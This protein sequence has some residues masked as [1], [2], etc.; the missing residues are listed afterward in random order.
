[1]RFSLIRKISSIVKIVHV[2][3]G[4]LPDSVGGSEVYCW[5]LCKQLQKQGIQAEVVI[6]GF[7]ENQTTEYY[8]DGIRVTRYA[9]PTVQSRLHI[10][11]LKLPEGLSYFRQYLRE[12]RPDCVHFHGLYPGIGITIQHLAIAKAMKIRV[13]YTMHIPGHICIN[14]TLI[15]NDVEPCDGIIRPLRCAAC[16]L[17]HRGTNKVVSEALAGVSSLLFNEGIDPGLWNN[18]LGT[19]LSAVDRVEDLKIMLAR[20]SILCDR[21]VVLARWFYD[22]M[23]ANHF[24]TEIMEY[25]PPGLTYKNESITNDSS[26]PF[27]RP[28]SIKLIYSGRIDPIKDIQL[29]VQIFNELPENKFELSIYGKPT[30]LSYYAKCRKL[31]ENNPDIHWRGVYS[32]QDLNSIFRQHDMLVLPSAVSEMSPMVI[33]EAFGAG[34]PVLASD[35]FGNHELITHGQNGLLFPFKS[36]S[37]LKKQLVRLVEEPDL[38]DNLRSNVQLPLDFEEVAIKYTELYNNLVFAT[39]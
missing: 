17:K 16:N 5:T 10:A 28:D 1:M 8:Y 12:S 14:Q 34:I 27:N 32:R 33:Q 39:A 18:R 23:A 7:G 3:P 38:L 30:D 13:V 37:D 26:V 4:F 35:V 36:G 24:P 6:P 19:A 2:I 9:E 11:G 15:H 25:M 31:S 21:V 29:L 22:M 20:L